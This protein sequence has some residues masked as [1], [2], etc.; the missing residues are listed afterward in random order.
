MTN[1]TPD[2]ITEGEFNRAV[3]EWTVQTRNKMRRNAPIGLDSRIDSEK[4][5]F[6]K[7]SVIKYHDVAG[8][9]KF[10]IERHGVFVHYGVG[11][12][13]VREGNRVIRGRTLERN[14]RYAAYRE[15][16]SREEVQK[17]KHAYTS[18]GP[19]K[20]TAVDWFDI[21]IKEGFGSLADI[22]Q[23]FYGDRALA[24]MLLQVDTALIEK[25]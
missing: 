2:L 17:M 13:Y 5:V 7:A 18:G 22:T 21:E 11:R 8:R 10:S 4:L 23:E 3:A 24:G 16:H 9:V 19:P 15:G 12:G 25:K 6:T 20:R 1:S 14:E